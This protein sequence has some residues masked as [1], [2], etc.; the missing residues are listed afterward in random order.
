MGF[1]NTFWSTLD[2]WVSLA[3]DHGECYKML[4]AL[5]NAS[6][7]MIPF[8]TADNHEWWAKELM[9]SVIITDCHH[10]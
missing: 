2:S 5:R 7:L 8:K 3:L 6:G 4:M 10:H 1:D 9:P